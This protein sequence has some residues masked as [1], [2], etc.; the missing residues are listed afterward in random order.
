MCACIWVKVSFQNE[1]HKNKTFILYNDAGKILKLFF[2]RRTKF[3]I[4]SL[5][6]IVFDYK[7]SA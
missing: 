7:H 5:R 6:L 2:Q 4:S 3:S 1:N